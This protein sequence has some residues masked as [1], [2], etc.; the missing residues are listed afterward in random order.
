MLHKPSSRNALR[1]SRN[2]PATKKFVNL[3]TLLLPK[4]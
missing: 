1:Q 3:S 4:T 2:T